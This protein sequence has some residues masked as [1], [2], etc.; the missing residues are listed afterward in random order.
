[1]KVDQEDGWEA[2][3]SPA[4][5]TA[6]L[7]ELLCEI[8]AT[9]ENGEQV[10]IQTVQELAGS[11]F[12]GPMLLFP[13]L[14]A[15][16]PLS[17]IP[18]VPTMIGTIVFLV[19]AQLAAGRKHLWFPPMIR[20]A[21]LKPS[22][23]STAVSFLRTPVYY[24]DLATRKRLKFLTGSIGLRLAAASCLIVAITMPPLEFVPFTSTLAG[25]VIAAFGLALTARDG[26]LMAIAFTLLAGIAVSSIYFMAV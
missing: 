1:M 25:I 2:G 18:F 5:G 19:S 12:A 21:G 9:A 7:S 16:S 26:L 8:E 15:A 4:D 10:S 20:N 11:R 6:S 23:V 3:K 13:G 14:V 17:G 24:L 22:K